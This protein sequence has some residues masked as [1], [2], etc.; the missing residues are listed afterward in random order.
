[1]RDELAIED[2]VDRT[3]E[4]DQ[5][6]AVGKVRCVRKGAE[7]QSRAVVVEE[8]AAVEVADHDALRKLGHQRREAAP[9]LLDLAACFLDALMHVGAQRVALAREPLD[10]LGEG[11]RG[12]IAVRNRCPH[13]DGVRLGSARRGEQ[14]GGAFGEARRRNHP[15]QV[16][17][18][19]ERAECCREHQPERQQQSSARREQRCDGGAL[20][21]VE[22]CREQADGD[23][24]DQGQQQAGRERRDELAP[25]QPHAS[26]SSSRTR[27][28]NSCVENGFVT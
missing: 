16:R 23:D 6:A 10:D 27:A 3:A 15:A 4:P 22:R 11:A 8:D 26:P 20:L 7:L 19:A 18:A 24:A 25:I 2:R 9:L 5:L 17:H 13:L 14:R 28:A 1:M 21:R 12:G